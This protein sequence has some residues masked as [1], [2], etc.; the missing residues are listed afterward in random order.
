MYLKTR[1]Y[2]GSEL[3]QASARHRASSCNYISIVQPT[4]TLNSTLLRIKIQN[5]DATYLSDQVGEY[6]Q[7]SDRMNVPARESPTGIFV[8]FWTQEMFADGRCKGGYERR[9][10]YGTRREGGDATTVMYA[11]VMLLKLPGKLAGIWSNVPATGT[12]AS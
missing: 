1:G 11:S 3:L 5:Y 6:V 12:Y 7:I 10:G 9:R 2:E 4:L 8:K